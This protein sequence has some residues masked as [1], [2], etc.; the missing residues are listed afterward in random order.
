MTNISKKLFLKF[1]R[2]FCEKWNTGHV[3][4]KRLDRHCEDDNKGK[5]GEQKSCGLECWGRTAG[6]EQPGQ[7]SQAR[8]GFLGQDIWDRTTRIGQPRQVTLDKST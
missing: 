2:E 1:L 4:Q 5:I 6:T 3:G 8:A 7:D